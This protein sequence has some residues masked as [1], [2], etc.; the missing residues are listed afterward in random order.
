MNPQE[1]ELRNV[2]RKF[3]K[4]SMNELEMGTAPADTTSPKPLKAKG[5]LTT[6][7][8]GGTASMRYAE[9]FITA[10][11]DLDD[12]K[13]AK[14]IAFVLARIGMN[15]KSLQQN[16]GRIKSSLKQYGN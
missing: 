1:K 2:I 13:K 12:M 9:D 3:V 4:E 5:G 8:L 11:Q 14:A 10:I 6:Q 16:L 15:T 7:Q